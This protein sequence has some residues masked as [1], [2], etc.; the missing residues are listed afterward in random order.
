MGFGKNVCHALGRTA[1][2]RRYSFQWF[3]EVN[4]HD[5]RWSC[6][7]DDHPELF[8]VCGDRKPRGNFFIETCEQGTVLGIAIGDFGS[9][10][11]RVSRRAVDAIEKYVQRGWFDEL[12][13]A[14]RFMVVFLTVTSCKADSLARQFERDSKNR[15]TTPLRRLGAEQPI[16]AD[17]VV[18]PGLVDML[19]PSPSKTRR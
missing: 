16:L 9:D 13:C 14:G 3:I 4:G 2:I 8:A 10:A 5:K 19:P 1:L 7:P 17:F 18:V 15:L 6:R 11:R 12:I